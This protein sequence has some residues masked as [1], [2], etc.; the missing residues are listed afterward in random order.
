MQYDADVLRAAVDSDF[1]GDTVH[2]KSV[3]GIVIKLTGGA[4]LYKT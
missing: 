4:V 3:S 2:R 1:A